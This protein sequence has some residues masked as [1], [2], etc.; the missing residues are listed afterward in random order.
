MPLPPELLLESQDGLA[1]SWRNGEGRIRWHHSDWLGSIHLLASAQSCRAGSTE[2]SEAADDLGSFRRLALRWEALA[3]PLATSVRAYR[4]HPLLVFRLE[5]LAPI[6]G[7][8]SGRFERPS[9]AWPWLRPDQRLPQGLPE[10]S[11]AVGHLYTEFAIPAFSDPSLTG[12]PM[13]DE[14]PRPA[15]VEPLWLIAPEGRCLLLAPLNAFHEQVIAVPRGP[16]EAERGVACGWHGDLDA[17]PAGFASELA[18]LAGGSPRALLERWGGWLRCRAGLPTRSRYAD[19]VLSHLSYWTDNGAA[20][21]YRTEPG[22]DMAATLERTIARLRAD[23]V[24]IRAV[25]LDSWFYPHAQTRPLNPDRAT[26]VPPT[27]CVAWEP[28]KDVLPEGMAALRHRLGNPPLILHGR[29][30]ASASPYFERHEAWRDGDRAHPRDGALLGGLLAQASTWGAAQYEQDW[31]IE[32]FL[33]VRGLRAAPGRARA[34]QE[35]LDRAAR[36]QGLTLLWCMA[37]PADFLQSTTL[38]SVTAIR[39]SGDYRYRIGNAALW[40]WYLHTNALARALDLPAFKDV[41]L[42]SV[43]GRGLDGDPH[44]ELEA[45]LAVMGAGPVGIGDRLGRTDRALVLRTC[46]DDGRLVKPDAAIAVLDRCYRSH[47]MLTRTPLVG[48]TYSQHTA[49]RWIYLV[50]I[51]VGLDSA[52]LACELPLQEI[53]TGAPEGP[54][55]AY[56]WRA[57]SASRIAASATLH[58]ELE[59]LDWCLFVLCPVLEG[60]IAVIGDPSRYATA[61]D[62]RLGDV[63][64]TPQGVFLEVHGAPG[65]RVTLTGVAESVLRATV[66]GG[67]RHPLLAEAPS[68]LCTWSQRAGRFELVLEIPSRGRAEI[69]LDRT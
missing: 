2:K 4:D 6:A 28:R 5:A 20:Y 63:R 19:P 69:L 30:F 53:G 51:H 55:V 11:S 52:P 49:G 13:L 1:F 39:T 29:H 22:L 33:G 62:A 9:V 41:F 66:S 42:S 8:A 58:F 64:T 60:G 61:G 18:I 35:G 31:L 47:A 48:E 27:G 50:A 23:G 46:R 57:R 7:L 43:E 21:W 40:L 15:V 36:A 25:Q 37:S 38:P 14:P 16:A 67:E 45:L 68:P 24:P 10:G 44:A 26:D 32:S 3:L 34:W 17:V 12:F 56:D 54:M 59:P 65:E